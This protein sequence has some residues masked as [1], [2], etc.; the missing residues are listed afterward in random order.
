MA[1]ATR[2]PSNADTAGFLPE[3]WSAKIIDAMQNLLV[4]W[5][6]FDTDQWRTDLKKGDKLYIPMTTHIAALE[7]VIGTIGAAASVSKDI[8][9]GMT[10]KSIT[11]DQWYEAPVD[12]DE[13]TALQSQVDWAGEIQK[14]MAYAI[15]KNMDTYINTLFYSLGGY[16]TTGYGSD[17]QTLTDDLLLAI[18]EVLDEADVP[19]DGN[20]SLI[21][22]PS[23]LVDLLKIDKFISTQYATAGKIEKGVIGSSPI[24]GCTVRVTNNLKAA[25]TGAYGVMAHKKAIGGISQMQDTW[26][27]EHKAY[28]ITRY[29]QEVLYGAGELRDDFGVPFFTRKA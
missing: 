12:V 1:L 18:K 2:V 27:E 24:Y 6:A 5:D 8:T 4:C 13:M 28:H 17:G 16:T 9:S 25:T 21:I 14:E 3:Q 11:I 10:A 19:Q 26:R 15:A 20:R 29:N 22:D 23:A 7:V